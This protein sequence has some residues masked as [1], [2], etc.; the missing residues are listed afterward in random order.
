MQYFK[1]E[2]FPGVN[3]FF[4]DSSRRW[5][6]EMTSPPAIPVLWVMWMVSC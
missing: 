4:S 3:V 1:K 2:A 5:G 6:I